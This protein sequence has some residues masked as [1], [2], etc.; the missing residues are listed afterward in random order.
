LREALQ[1]LGVL[2]EP[3]QAAHVTAIRDEQWALW[4]AQIRVVFQAADASWPVLRQTL[5]EPPN[6]APRT[7]RWPFSGRGGQR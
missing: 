5:G 7:P 4:L 6:A 3:L 2:V 1:R